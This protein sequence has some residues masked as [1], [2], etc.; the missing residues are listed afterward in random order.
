[1]SKHSLIRA[2]AD[3]SRRRQDATKSWRF[4]Q[5]AKRPIWP[6]SLPALAGEIHDI[7]GDDNVSDGVAVL[8]GAAESRR[9]D[10]MGLER[11]AFKL[12]LAKEPVQHP[13]CP[14]RANAGYDHQD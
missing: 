5:A 2:G 4:V 13:L 8:Q 6:R 1:M 11:P 14:L 3:D 7:R 12:R 9:N 10:Q